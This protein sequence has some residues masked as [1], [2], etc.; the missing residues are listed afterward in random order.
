[1][2][3]FRP[4]LGQF[5]PRRAIF[6]NSPKKQKQ[7]VNSTWPK[8]NEKNEGKF[9]KKMKKMTKNAKN[10]WKKWKKLG[11]PYWFEQRAGEN[12]PMNQRYIPYFG[13]LWPH[14]VADVM[15][16]SF[17]FLV[18]AVAASPS[19]SRLITPCYSSLITGLPIILSK[20]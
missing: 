3:K 19:S 14:I 18:A 5:R 7:A 20:K 12:W 10:K 6:E 4:N 13:A 9:F 2:V 8:K 11:F 1:M 16:I 17:C 15:R